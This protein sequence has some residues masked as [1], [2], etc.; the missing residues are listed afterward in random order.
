MKENCKQLNG[1]GLKNLYLCALKSVDRGIVLE[2][3]AITRKKRSSIEIDDLLFLLSQN[4][5]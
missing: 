1:A 2:V 3:W 5:R 4:K